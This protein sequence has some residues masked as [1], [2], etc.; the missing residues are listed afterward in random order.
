MQPGHVL[1]MTAGLLVGCAEFPELGSAVSPAAQAA[2]YP[3][4]LSLDGLLAAAA[5]NPASPAV[6]AALQAR[7]DA[8]RARAAALRAAP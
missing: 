1:A 2:P 7:A 4:L 3:A 8:L 6:I 5:V